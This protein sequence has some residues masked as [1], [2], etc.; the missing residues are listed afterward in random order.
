LRNLVA[1]LRSEDCAVEA[2]SP[3][4]PGLAAVSQ[5]LVHTYLSHTDKEVR[6]YTVL[7]CVEILTIVRTVPYPNSVTEARVHG[8]D[9]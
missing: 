6:L 2:E 9:L 5:T 3:E 4:W 8:L 1:V 7:A